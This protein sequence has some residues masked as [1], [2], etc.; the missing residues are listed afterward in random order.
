MDNLSFNCLYNLACG[1]ASLGLILKFSG[2][3]KTLLPTSIPY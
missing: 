2:R 1:A 3:F